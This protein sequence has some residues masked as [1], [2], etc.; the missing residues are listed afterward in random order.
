MGQRREHQ[1][2]RRAGSGTERRSHQS[3][4]RAPGP[5][6]TPP[7]PGNQQ[8]YPSTTPMRPPADASSRGGSASASPWPLGPL[9]TY[10]AP[11]ARG[12]G[13]PSAATTDDAGAFSYPPTPLATAT[14]AYEPLAAASPRGDPY[15]LGRWRAES[16][17][18]GPLRVVPEF[19]GGDGGGGAGATDN[20]REQLSDTG[21]TG[22]RTPEGWR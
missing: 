16:L 8:A 5:D 4:A 1:G 3:P 20:E 10:Y 21:A 2:E 11:P 15:S 17:R 12:G 19:C 7:G 13:I 6:N 14:T 18:D 9:E 22:S